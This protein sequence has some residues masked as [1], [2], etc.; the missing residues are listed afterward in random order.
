MRALRMQT[1]TQDNYLHN[2]MTYFI[3]IAQES[4]L[5]CI[6]VTVSAMCLNEI[7]TFAAQRVYAS[8]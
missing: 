1:R 5:S 8:F 6:V 2:Q 7:N 4:R 3:V